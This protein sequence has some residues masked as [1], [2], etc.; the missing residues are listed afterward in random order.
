MSWVSHL[1]ISALRGC[2]TLL[3]LAIVVVV[4]IIGMLSQLA[5]TRFALVELFI[6]RVCLLATF[7]HM[8]VLVAP[9]LGK[10]LIWQCR[11]A[12][13]SHNSTFKS[14]PCL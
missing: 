6:G 14:G 13:L 4:P 8:I 5:F 11:S 12:V 9:V 10:A 1:A 7:S 2:F 3:K